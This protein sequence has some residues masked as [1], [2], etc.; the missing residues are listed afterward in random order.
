M[1]KNVPYILLVKH[2]CHFGIVA[3]PLIVE[4]FSRVQRFITM[5]IFKDRYLKTSALTLFFLEI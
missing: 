1:A 5:R 2:L 4:I 3:D